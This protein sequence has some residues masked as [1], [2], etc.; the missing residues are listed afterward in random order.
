MRPQERSKVRPAEDGL[1][2]FRGPVLEGKLQHW[3]S[4]HVTHLGLEAQTKVGTGA[5]DK[6]HA[7]TGF[8]AHWGRTGLLRPRVSDT[9]LLPTHPRTHTLTHWSRKIPHKYRRG[10]F[11]E[12]RCCGAA[13]LNWMLVW[14]MVSMETQ[15]QKRKLMS[16]CMHTHCACAYSHP[17]PCTYH[18]HTPRSAHSEGGKKQPP[19]AMVT[20]SAQHAIYNPI[21][22]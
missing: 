22:Q 2:G 8:G 18:P 14:P 17:C 4:G 11:Q 16:V 15:T 21:S 3:A 1:E 5:C 7:D 10:K 20:P 13:G 12:T 19:L 9:R 6:A